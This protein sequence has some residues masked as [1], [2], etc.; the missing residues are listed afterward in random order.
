M[1]IYSLS[2]VYERNSFGELIQLQT[3][4]STREFTEKALGIRISTIRI[5]LMNQNLLR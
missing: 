5:E 2:I 3:E 1:F 4:F